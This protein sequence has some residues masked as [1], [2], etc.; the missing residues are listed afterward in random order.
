VGGRLQ[1]V[2]KRVSHVRPFHQFDHQSL[3]KSTAF[4]AATGESY[5]NSV[6]VVAFETARVRSILQYDVERVDDAGDITQDRE[7]DVD[8]EVGI[9]AA[10]QED[11]EGW[12]EDG[13]DDLDDV[14]SRERHD[15]GCPGVNSLAGWLYVE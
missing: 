8:E 7:E 9:A 11:T 5:C 13:E 1:I 3:V 10:F 14:A 4:A 15:G 12:D 6:A 2:Q